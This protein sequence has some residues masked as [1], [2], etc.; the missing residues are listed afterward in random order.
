MRCTASDSLRCC[1]EQSR[2]AGGEQCVGSG[3]TADT[4]RPSALLQV[5]SFSVF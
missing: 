3:K 2:I 1:E 4:G 5:S